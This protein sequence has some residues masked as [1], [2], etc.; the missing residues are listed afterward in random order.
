M[1]SRFNN[2]TYKENRDYV[3][4]LNKVKCIYCCPDPIARSIPCDANMLVL[5]MNNE[6]NRIMGIGKIKNNA[7]IQKFKV[8]NENNYNRYQYIGTQHI[9]RMSMN[10]EEEE[11][12]KKFDQWCFKGLGHMKRGQGIKSFPNERLYEYSKEGN[13]SQYL[14]KMFQ[15]RQSEQ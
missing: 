12:M 3:Q 1:T 8:Y 13:I 7:K 15:K 5:E 4:T 14:H 9:D 6:E 2:E 10:E 11:L